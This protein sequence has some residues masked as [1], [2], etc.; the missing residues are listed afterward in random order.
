M[1]IF[2]ITPADSK[3]HD[4]GTASPFADDSP[5]ADVLTLDTGAFLI[6]SNKMDAVV[7][8]NTGGWTVTVN[9]SILSTQL[10]DGIELAAGNAG[11]SKITISADGDVGG[12]GS[13]IRVG[14]S[15]TIANAGVVSGQ[16]NGISIFGGG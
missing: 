16:N 11:A 6:A 13:A 14:S 7:L 3:F 4:T 1:A 5:G 2:K 15:T 10:G 9:G 12:A 8:G